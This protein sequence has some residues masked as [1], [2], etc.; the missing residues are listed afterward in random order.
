MRMKLWAKGYPIDKEVEDYVVGDGY[1]LDQALV[2]YDCRASIAHAEMLGRIGILSPAEVKALVKCLNEITGLDAKGKFKITKE[3]EDCHTAIENYL[4]GKLGKAGKKIHTARSRNDQ[5][6]AAL[7]LYYKD[8]LKN[9]ISLTLRLIASLRRFTNK[10]G[11]I[12]IPGY[13]HTRKAMPSSV[14]LWAGALIESLDGDIGLLNFAYKLN[15]QSPLGTGAGYGLPIMVDRAFVAKKLGFAR[16]QN[17]PIYVQN[18]RGKFESTIVHALSQVMLDLDRVSR[19]LIIFSMPEF[20]YYIIPRELT[21]GSSIM[22]QKKNP[23][24]LELVR[25]NYHVVNAYGA[26]IQGI[27]GSVP[28][29]YNADVMLTKAPAMRSFEI[30]ERSI[31]IMALLFSKL[32]VDEEASKRAMSD[33]LYAT[34]KVY[35]LVKKGVP[36]RDAYKRISS[37]YKGK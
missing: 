32:K 2:K 17:N 34:A 3:Q 35:D 7:R 6:Q 18:S 25:A 5:V 22:P 12:K 31:S 20:G 16:V 26:M 23:D 24:V 1:L 27:V 13:T 37:K 36:F 10:Y 9:T 14:G 11:R 19:D 21:T 8:E 4:T 30:T 29:G 33:E 28:S 15:D